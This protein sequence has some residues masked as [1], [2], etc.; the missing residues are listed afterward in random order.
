MANA[1]ITYEHS[2]TKKVLQKTGLAGFLHSKID[3]T[4]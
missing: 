2:F 3:G 4:N 1:K